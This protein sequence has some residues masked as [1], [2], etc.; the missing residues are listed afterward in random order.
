M[1][2]F[3]FT[4]EFGKYISVDVRDAKNVLSPLI[5]RGGRHEWKMIGGDEITH[6]SKPCTYRLFYLLVPFSLEEL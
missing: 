1:E 3:D 4:E 5:K 6:C 2:N